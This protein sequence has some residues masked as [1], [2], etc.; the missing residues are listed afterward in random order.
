MNSF[1]FIFVLLLSSFFGY[2]YLDVKRLETILSLKFLR[3]IAVV[4]ILVSVC[5]RRWHDHMIRFAETGYCNYRSMHLL[6]LLWTEIDFLVS[7]SSW[8]IAMMQCCT[9][10]WEYLVTH[11]ATYQSQITFIHN[12]AHSSFGLS[13]LP[14]MEKSNAAMQAQLCSS[15]QFLKFTKPDF[16]S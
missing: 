9:F 3:N 11:Q 6:M 15:S 10:L 13:L 2:N 5:I 4:S 16:T 1:W 14:F 12:F 8:I 7:E